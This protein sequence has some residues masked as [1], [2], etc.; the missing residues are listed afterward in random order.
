M[1][2]PLNMLVIESTSKHLGDFLKMIRAE[3]IA[4]KIRLMVAM[5]NVGA[6]EQL[7]RAEAVIT[8][9]D[10]STGTK[11]GW[12]KGKRVIELFLMGWKAVFSISNAFNDSWFCYDFNAWGRS[13]GLTVFGTNRPA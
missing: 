13:R 6:I 4:S 12:P 8:D 3:R 9:V 10:V 11:R 1:N 7:E 5:S 2:D